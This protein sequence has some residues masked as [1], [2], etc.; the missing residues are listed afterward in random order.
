[1]TGRVIAAWPSFSL[2][3]AYE[4]LMRQVRRVTE[5]PAPEGLTRKSPGPAAKAATARASGPV[6]TGGA[7]APEHRTAGRDV[8]REAWRWAQGNRAEDGSLPSDRDIGSRY[9]RHER[10]GRMVKQSGLAGEI[11]A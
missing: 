11:G 5:L 2:I 7:V 4:L 1:M 9:G 10:W 6:T 3:A 8:Q